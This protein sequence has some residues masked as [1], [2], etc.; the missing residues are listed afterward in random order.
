MLTTRPKALPLVDASGIPTLR[1]I[2]DVHGNVDLEKVV[3]LGKIYALAIDTSNDEH[4]ER[5]GV[6]HPSSCGYCMRAEVLQFL[7]VPPT[8][9]QS[10][11]VKEI[12]EMGHLVHDLVQSKFERLA[13][14]MKARGLNYMFQ[15]EV[16]YDPTADRLYLELGIGG[17][18]DGVVRIW[19]TL[20]EQRILLEAKSQSDDRHKKLLKMATAWPT[21]L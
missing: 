19:N 5:Q 20:F 13:P 4:L 7:R 15:R 6:W 18:A 17:T 10:P 1:S 8:D 16:P 11:E 12:F 21:H 2:E 9:E 3:D 14:H